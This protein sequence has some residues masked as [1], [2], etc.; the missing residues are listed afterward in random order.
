[1]LK[2]PQGLAHCRLLNLGWVL[3]APS[4]GLGA[5]SSCLALE[6]LRMVAARAVRLCL[7][8]F[9]GGAAAARAGCINA[10]GASAIAQTRCDARLLTNPGCTTLARAVCVSNADD[11]FVSLSGVC[12]LQ[13]G[14]HVPQ[15]QPR[16]DCTT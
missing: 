15:S 3:R 12:C 13:G 6:W 5:C 8:L 9:G 2:A 1:V 7:N 14:G 16:V 11:V 4:P 10:S